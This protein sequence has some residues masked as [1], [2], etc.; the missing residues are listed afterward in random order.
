M[1]LCYTGYGLGFSNMAAPSSNVPDLKRCNSFTY[2]NAEPTVEPN[3]LEYYFAS[4]ARFLVCT[5]N[6]TK[7]LYG[8]YMLMQCGD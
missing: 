5:Y 3:H 4:D 1:M 6:Y 8:V 2:F 7:V